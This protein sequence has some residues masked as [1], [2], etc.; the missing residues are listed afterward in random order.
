MTR[1]RRGEK[2][3]VNNVYY[4]APAVY[5]G[6]SGTQ[7]SILV[8][9]PGPDLYTQP[10]TDSAHLWQRTQ[11]GEH[12]LFG[13]HCS[14]DANDSASLKSAFYTALGGTS[15]TSRWE[16]GHHHSP[17]CLHMANSSSPPASTICV[18]CPDHWQPQPPQ[19]AIKR[20]LKYGRMAVIRW[21]NGW[22]SDGAQCDKKTCD[23]TPQMAQELHGLCESD[24]PL[25]EHRRLRRA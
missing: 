19:Q 12:L 23:M 17:R 22:R 21:M 18:V 10:P 24:I 16:H 14:V 20:T 11:S 15:A 13:A 3:K 1:R 6:T 2:W 4:Y 25:P 9:R 5:G 7:V 8:G